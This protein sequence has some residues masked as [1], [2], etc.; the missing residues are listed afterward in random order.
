MLR[1]ALMSHA[2]VRSVVGATAALALAMLIAAPAAAQSGAYPNRPITMLVP[3]AAGGVTDVVARFVANSMS[4][5]LGQPIVVENRVGAGGRI[6][7]TAGKQ[8]APD[9]YTLLIG[10]AGTHAAAPAIG[11][12]ETAYD[13]AEDFTFIAPLGSYSFVLICNPKIGA[14]DVRELIALAKEHKEGLTYGSAGIGS[15]VNFIF[16]YFKRQTGTNFTHVPYRGAGPMLNDI[17]SG[18]LDCTFDGT[19]KKHIEAGTV[20]ALAIA[21]KDPDP[22]YPDL[23]TVD[24]AG[25]PG[26]DLTGWQG[27][28]GPKGIPQEIIA[29]LAEAANAAARDPEVIER[30]ALL[31]F[32]ARGGT[33]EELGEVTRRDSTLY[34]TIAKEAGIA[35]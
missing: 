19:S 15:Q 16:E 18:Q 29:K 22:L 13:P 30:L 21:G 9:G 27:L 3:Y 23:P 12:Q 6:G 11:G 4:R 31:G 24:K 8:A 10:N 26:F 35:P 2:I 20:R 14:Q 7:A 17:L 1:K 32:N 5:T 28:M 33:P 25:V 34:R